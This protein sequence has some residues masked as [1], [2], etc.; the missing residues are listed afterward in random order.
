MFQINIEFKYAE[1]QDFS[2]LELD[3]HFFVLVK[4]K[5]KSKKTAESAISV[6]MD[7]TAYSRYENIPYHTSTIENTQTL[8]VE[9]IN[10]RIGKFN[11]RVGKRNKKA[12]IEELPNLVW[13]ECVHT[14]SVNPFRRFHSF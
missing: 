4:H 6:L 1:T 8:T 2:V 5:G 11:E 14:F 3:G 12:T 13:T 7:K 9:F 10:F